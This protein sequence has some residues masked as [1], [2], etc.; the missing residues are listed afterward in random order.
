[1]DLSSNSRAIR[2]G[3]QAKER[4]RITG[5]TPLGRKLWSVEDDEIVKALYPSYADMKA[6]LPERTLRALHARCE[7]LGIAKKI[8]WWLGSEI[9]KLRRLYPTASRDKLRDEFSGLTWPAI[10]GAACRYGVKR[11][12]RKYK[13]TGHHLI[14]A[15]LA[16]IEEIGW[17]LR[18]LD[19][20]SKTGRYFRNGSW[21]RS[22]PNYGRLARAAKALDGRLVVEWAAYN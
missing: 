8:H 18:D 14:D 12:R 11:A 15:I 7:A 4:M 13:R 6:R 20:E 5:Y 19:E 1:M 21:R 2:F 3:M 9:A 10:Q 17:T 16:R 22:K